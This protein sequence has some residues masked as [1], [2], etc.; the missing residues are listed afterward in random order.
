M[1][2]NQI[3][4][5]D[6]AA[7]PWRNGGGIT[8]ELVVWPP[9]GEWQWRIT[10][11]EVAAGGPFSRFDGVDRWFAVLG[12]AG[13]RLDIAGRSYMLDVD[14]APLQFDGAAD[15]HCTLVDG[16]SQDFNLMLRRGKSPLQT[17]LESLKG[18]FD[19]LINAPKIIAIQTINTWATARIDS[20]IIKIP[21]QTLAW[22]HFERIGALR[23]H[24]EN[25]LC[26]ELAI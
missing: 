3:A 9:Q 10:V 4:W 17:R 21:P 24:S 11:A 15:T 26:M 19:I 14:S 6:V 16:P 13:V 23:L 12:G 25:A 5:A 7:R 8:H 2:W 20:E 22:R 18:D 1:G